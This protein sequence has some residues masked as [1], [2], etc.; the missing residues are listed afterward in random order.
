MNLF[1]IRQLGLWI[2]IGCVLTIAGAAQTDD[3]KK[4]DSQQQKEKIGIQLSDPIES[5]WE[6]GVK[7]SCSGNGKQ[8]AVVSP[9]PMDWPEQT[10]EIVTEIKTDNVGKLVHKNATKDARQ[11][12]FGVNQM[13][14]GQNA[15]A[16]VKMKI[17]KR[18]ITAPRDKT[19]FSI[20]KKV[21]SAL[22]AFLKPSPLIESKD[23]RIKEIA[24][25]IADEVSYDEKELHLGPRKGQI[26][27]RRDQSK[28]PS[29]AR[30]QD[31]RL[32]R[33]F[34]FIRCDL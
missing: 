27:I 3:S 14:A 28:L 24:K 7:I 22:K 33:A 9:I 16:I 20:P 11:F 15:S 19:Q 25:A 29:C 18:L 13:M 10:V 17:K 4:K 32:W 5:V 8:I 21:P 2:A 6:F 30:K 26:Q 23:K 34:V 12:S 1:S 31:W